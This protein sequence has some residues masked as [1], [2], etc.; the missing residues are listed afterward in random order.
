MH[1][2]TQKC[3]LNPIFIFQV[4]QLILPLLQKNQNCHPVLKITMITGIRMMMELGGMSMMMKVSE[5]T[6]SPKYL[7]SDIKLCFIEIA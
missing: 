1:I 7:N 3:D 5:Y 2:S 6:S 4:A